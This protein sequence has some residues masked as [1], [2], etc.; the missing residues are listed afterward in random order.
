MRRDFEKCGVGSFSKAPNCYI[1]A[2]A[3]DTDAGQNGDIQGTSFLVELKVRVFS[4]SN[5]SDLFLIA[6]LE[7]LEIRS[8]WGTTACTCLHCCCGCFRFG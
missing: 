3:I 4:S 1:D 6:Q 5:L 2:P 7:G 8:P